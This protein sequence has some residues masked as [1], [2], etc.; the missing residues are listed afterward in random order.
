M[1]NF[2]ELKI[3]QKAHEVTLEV[4]K[5]TSGFPK[6]EIFGLTAQARRAAGSMG[7]NI[8]EGCGREGEADFVRFLHIARGSACELEY[9]LLLAHDLGV[10][11]GAAYE[12]LNGELTEVKRMLTGFIQKVNARRQ[13]PET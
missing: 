8:A 13:G 10:L 4:Y 9:H 3:W 6:Q 11:N 1:R 12:E 7:A 2:R 5:V